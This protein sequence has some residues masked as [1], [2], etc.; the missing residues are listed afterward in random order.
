[1]SSKLCLLIIENDCDGETTKTFPGLIE[2]GAE[3]SLQDSQKK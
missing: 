2:S 1:M 3:I